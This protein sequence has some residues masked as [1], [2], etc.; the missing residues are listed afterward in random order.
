M[1][2]NFAQSIL[3]SS[4]TKS[5]TE[6]KLELQLFSDVVGMS[7]VQHGSKPLS[8]LIVT[9]VCL[10]EEKQKLKSMKEREDEVAKALNDAEQ[11][12]IVLE[13]ENKV[14]RVVFETF[15]AR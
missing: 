7:I 9:S 1:T 15:H 3:E 12:N 2:E 10:Q 4:V 5:Y 8:D 14:I 6:K 13:D 11:K